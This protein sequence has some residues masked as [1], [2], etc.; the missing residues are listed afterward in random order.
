MENSFEIKKFVEE[1]TDPAI[2]AEEVKEVLQAEEK[3][4]SIKIGLSTH[5][6]FVMIGFS[7]TTDSVM[8]TK[9]SARQLAS[10]LN[11]LAMS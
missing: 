7:R 10:M 3:K 6:G 9:K 5:L 8:M 4:D 1:T 11:K 2:P